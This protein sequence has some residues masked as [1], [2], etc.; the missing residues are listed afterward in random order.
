MKAQMRFD[1]FSTSTEE[2]RFQMEHFVH[3]ERDNQRD[4]RT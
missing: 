3:L 1:F 4:G 2:P